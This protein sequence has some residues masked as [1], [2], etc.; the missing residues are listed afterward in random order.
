MLRVVTDE[1]ARADLN[2]DL[3]EIVREGARR[4]LAAAIEAEADGY[5]S[6]GSRVLEWATAPTG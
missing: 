6:A 4:M 2:A 1:D 5:V 3:D